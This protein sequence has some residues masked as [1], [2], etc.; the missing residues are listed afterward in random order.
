MLPDFSPVI[1]KATPIID[2]VKSQPYIATIAGTAF[3]LGIPALVKWYSDHKQAENAISNY[4]VA[5]SEAQNLNLE[6][7]QKLYD[8]SQDNIKLQNHLDEILQSEDPLADVR[9]KLLE[10]EDRNKQLE[11][12][13]AEARSFIKTLQTPTDQI[14]IQRLE[15]QGYKV[16]KLV[17]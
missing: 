4:K 17:K 13:L 11:S 15:Q 16:S 14:M 7:Q 8:L 12:S 6:G 2:L 10:A 1:D 3:S 9:N 5:L